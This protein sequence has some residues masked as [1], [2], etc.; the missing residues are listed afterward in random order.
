MTTI[1]N[2]ISLK[3]LHTFKLPYRARKVIEITDPVALAD[4]EEDYYVLGEGSNTLFTSDFE[5][6]LVRVA[7][8]GITVER[9]EDF[10]LLRVGAGENW[11]QFVEYTLNNDMPGLENL[12]LIPGSVGAAPVQNIGAYGVEVGEY[13]Y[14]VHAWDRERKE[15]QVFDR[16]A[17]Q[18]A[19]RDSVFKRSAGRYVI[20]AVEFK[21]P[22]TWAPRLNYGG[23]AKETLNE[24]PAAIKDAVIRIRQSKLP[25][26]QETPNAGSFFK[27]PVISQQ[28]FANLQAQFA[29]APSYPTADGNVKVAAGWLIDRLGLKG[30]QIGEAAVHTKQALVLINKGHATGTD[31]LALSSE[32]QRRVAETFKIPLE[33][34]VRI[35]NHK[36]LIS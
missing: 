8:K 1:Q 26:P 20:V 17:C 5:P 28:Q 36:E 18:F 23:L 35:L 13:I 6:T 30:F 31:V 34:E 33:I 10:A 9:T 19:Y 15:I 2:N 12:A 32:I 11:H 27:N 22:H 4:I 14:R 29:D 7:I 21:L 16:Q 3:S 24:S 25:D